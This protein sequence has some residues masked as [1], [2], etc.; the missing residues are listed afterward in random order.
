MLKTPREFIFKAS[1]TQKGTN[2]PFP[3]SEEGFETAVRDALTKTL[4]RDMKE[5]FG[6]EISV[7]IK[8]AKHGSLTIF[9]G[10]IVAGL[11]ALSRYKNVFDSI[12]LIRQQAESVLESLRT[13]YGQFNIGVQAIYPR[14]RDPFDRHHSLRHEMFLEEIGFSVAPYSRRDGFFYF[15]LIWN[16]ISWLVISALVYAAVIKTYFG[17]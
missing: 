16:I 9:F 5:I 13:R 3:S 7:D 12:E 2:N 15:L 10:V 11:A 17:R 4:P 6:V 14:L 1:L 8:A